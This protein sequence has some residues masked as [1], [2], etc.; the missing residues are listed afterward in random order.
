MD[1]GS[2]PYAPGAG[3]R[4]PLLAGRD[5][6][7]ANAT[8]ALARAKRGRHGKSFVAVGL[9]G[10]GKTVVLNRVLELAEAEKYQVAY[11][12]AHD[13]AS[14][15]ALLLPQLRSIMVRINKMEGAKDIGRKGI[16]VLK[17]FAN[18][19]KINI[20]DIEVGL[21]FENEAGIADSGDL[22]NDLPELFTALGHA[23]ADKKNGDRH[24]YR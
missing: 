16:S 6:L 3:T 2:N 24:T 11:I 5:D 9:R 12:E 18:A 20:A 10:V 14:L 15:A 8:V 13:N 22:A 7:V 17:N 19:V 1:V 23:A 4:P 21:A